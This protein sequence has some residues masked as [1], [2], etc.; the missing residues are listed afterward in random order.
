M[1]TWGLLAM[2]N[3][4]DE[5]DYPGSSYDGRQYWRQM[6]E[7]D[8]KTPQQNTGP[9]L[10]NN[11]LKQLQDWLRSIGRPCPYDGI[12]AVIADC[13]DHIAN[14][15]DMYLVIGT[16][17]LNTSFTLNWKGT[18]APGPVY[19]EDLQGLSTNCGDLL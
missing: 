5:H 18:D 9:E 4:L 16:T 6:Q 10:A 12:L 11:N 19:A 2:L 1:L 7:Q 8:V 13:L 17:R 15:H 14:G 3:P